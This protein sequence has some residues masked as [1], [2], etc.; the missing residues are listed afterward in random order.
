MQD[1]NKKYLIE[2]P[3]QEGVAYWG[4]DRYNANKDALLKDHPDAIIAEIDTYSADD[5]NDNDMYL[6]DVPGQQGSAYWDANRFN[7]N[8]DAL[9]KDHP[10]AQIQRV[11]AVDYWGEQRADLE[12]Q[13]QEFDAQYGTFLDGYEKK[14]K[15]DN[16][17]AGSDPLIDR[18]NAEYLSKNEEEYNRLNAE[19]ER[20]GKQYYNSE[21]VRRKRA[22]EINSI[23]EFSSQID[24]EWK[25][26]YS[27]AI[28]KYQSE[29]GNIAAQG[30]SS[31]IDNMA[32]TQM[33][34]AA[35]KMLQEA[36]DT[37]EAPSKSDSSNG[38]VNFMKGA[39]HTFGSADF[40][41][42]GLTEIADNSKIRAAF[43][44]LAQKE[45]TTD[46]SKLTEEQID[47]ALSP[48]EK[49]AVLAFTQKALADYERSKDIS[50]GYK[51][52]QS[53]AESL[54]F[55]AQFLLTGGVTSA[56]SKGAT[57]GLA[58]WLAKNVGN[59]FVAKA[60]PGFAKLGA[61]ALQ[62]GGKFALGTTRS[63]IDAAV[64]T[65]MT[66]TLG[67]SISEQALP[68]IYQGTLPQA[69]EYILKGLGDAFIEN[70]S[71]AYG[72]VLSK[73]V[74]TPAT[75]MFG[76]WGKVI[77]RSPM[78]K[79]L[80]RGG[81][82]GYLSE[83]GEEWFGSAM[84]TLTGVDPDALKNFWEK[85]NL[86]VTATSFL[87]M[88]LIGG[89]VSVGQYKA[90]GK[91][92][93]NKAAELRVALEK[94]GMNMDEIDALVDYRQQLSPKMLSDRFT[95]IVARLAQTGSPRSA[96]EVMKAAYGFSNAVARYQ[97]MEGGYQAQ[98]S[99]DREEY[100]NQLQEQLQGNQFWTTRTLT[101]QKGEE[102]TNQNGEAYTE[103]EVRVITNPDGSRRFVVG[104]NG[105]QIAYIDE[106]G[107]TGYMTT[108]ELPAAKAE[109]M[110]NLTEEERQAIRD[111]DRTMK[112]D[113]FLE[114]EVIVRRRELEVQRMHEERE[115]QKAD[116]RA[117]HPIGTQINLGTRA[118]PIAGTIIGY[119]P[120]AVTV[121]TNDKENPVKRISY[122]QLGQAFNT[123]I[124][125]L[126]DEQIAS[127]EAATIEAETAEKETENAVT[128]QDMDSAEDS[129]NSAAELEQEAAPSIVPTN[130]D[131]SV[132][133]QKFLEENPEEYVAWNDA[134]RQDGGADSM[135]QLEMLIPVY[136]AQYDQ[137]AKQWAANAADPVARRAAKESMAEWQDK[138][139]RINNLLDKYRTPVQE[140]SP[141]AERTIQEELE[142]LHDGSLNDAEIA[143][144]IDAHIA[145]AQAAYDEYAKNAP[146]M[147]TD[148]SAYKKAK[149]EYE[150]GLKE[151]EQELNYW[152]AV[153]AANETYGQVASAEEVAQFRAEA[154]E[155]NKELM[156]QK[157]RELEQKLGVKVNVI[158]RY[159]DIRNKKAKAAIANGT[160]IYGWYNVDADTVE[161]YLPGNKTADSIVLTYIHEVVGHK[162][163][164]G[165]LGKNYDALLD[166]VYQWMEANLN[167]DQLDFWLNYE[168][169]NGDTRKAADEYLANLAERVN[170][171]DNLT[172]WDK[173]ISKIK[174]ILRRLGIE[175]NM[176]KKDFVNLIKRSYE[177]LAEEA[178]RQGISENSVTPETLENGTSLFS[179]KTYREGGRE[180]LDMWL[181]SDNT[182]SEEERKY[183]LDTMDFMYNAA[184]GLAEKY[185]AFGAWSE[186]DVVRNANGDP[187]MSVI[188]ANGD[189]AMNLDFSLVCKKRRAL[190]ALLNKMIKDGRFDGM[191]L[192]EKEIARIN[193]ILQKHGFEVAC[194]LC[195]VD[196]KRYRVANVATQFTEMYN[197]LV[198]S[199]IPK[200]SGYEALWYNY[201]GEPNQKEEDERKNPE[202]V[203]SNLPEEAL[204]WTRIDRI[205]K[206]AEGKKQLNVQEKIAKLLK[207]GAEYRKLASASDFIS[208][209]GFE[210]VT[211]NNPEL[212]KLYNAKKGT[213][214][215]KASLGD[216]QY[217]NNIAKSQAFSA[218]KAYK[219]GGVR[220]QS[221]SDYM[222]HM[223]FDYMQMMAELAGK[224]LPAHA[225]TKEPA[226]ARLFGMTGMKINLSLVPRVDMDGIAPGLD[227]EGNYTW[228]V[229][230]V[231]EQGRTIATQTF[232]PEVAFE[233]QQDPRYSGNVGAIAV[234]ISDEHIL[235][236]LS[237]ANIHFI[238]PYHKSSLNPEVAKMA[239][240]DQYA[241]YTNYQ[242]EKLDPSHPDAP[243]G[244]LTA[245]QKKA[246]INKRKF[247]F[248][249]SLAQTNDPKQTAADYLAHCK[250]KGLI[251]KFPQFAS[252]EN[253]YKLL[254]DFN[255][256]DFV[257]GEYAPQGAVTM[258]FP[259]NMLELIE[260]GLVEDQQLDDKLNAEISEVAE[261]VYEEIGTTMFKT[262]TD[263]QREKLFADAK[264]EFGLTDNFNVAGYMLPDGSLLNFG[265]PANPTTRAEDHRA[266]EG[267]IMDNGT[268]YES[269]WMYLA[270]FMNEGAIRLLP[271]YAGINL[272]KAPTKE[273]R[274]RLMDFIYKYNGEVILEIADE[275]LNNAAYVEYDRRTSPARIFRDIDGYFNEGIVPQQDNTLFKTANR[276][277]AIFISNAAKAVEGIQMGKA[278]PEQWLKTLEKNG[279]LKAAEDKWLGLSDWLKSSDKKSITKEELL[280]FIN[281]N[282]IQ[283]EEVHYGEEA[284][285]KEALWNTIE[286]S[287]Q[288]RKAIEEQLEKDA[289]EFADEMMRGSSKSGDEWVK[290]HEELVREYLD[291]D[292]LGTNRNNAKRQVV[293]EWMK[294][295]EV[296]PIHPTRQ[297]YQTRGLTNNHEIALTVPTIE[298]WEGPMPDVHFADAGEGRAVAWVR[299]GDAKKL[300]G[301]SEVDGKKKLNW[302]K[303]LVIDEVQSQRHQEGREKG[304]ESDFETSDKLQELNAQLDEKVARRG[305][306]IREKVANEENE[307]T[308]I[309]RL[310]IMLNEVE[311][312]RNYDRISEE[313]ASIEASIENRTAEIE[314]LSAEINEIE[315]DIKREE[316]RLDYKKSEAVKDAPFEKNWH[317]LAMKRMLRYA[318]ENGYDVIAWTKGDQQAERYNIGKIYNE[319]EREDNPNIEGRTFTFSGGNYDMVTVNEDGVVV[320][321]TI[322]EAKGKPLSDLVGK[323]LAVKMMSL[324]NYDTIDGEDLRIGGEGMKGFYDKMLPSFMNKYGKKWGVKVEDMTFPGLEGG[325]TMHSIPVTEEMKESVMEGQLMFRTKQ[326]HEFT[327]QFMQG[328]VDNFYGTYNTAAPASVVY[329]KNRRMVE[330]ALG[331]GKGEMPDWLY[332]RVKEEAKESG[333]YLVNIQHDKEDG[334]TDSWRRILIFAKDE[335]NMSADV[336]RITFHENTH[337]FILD[338]PHWLE[339]GKWLAE[340][341]NKT[342]QRVVGWIKDAY[343]QESWANEMLSDYVGRMLSIGKGQ[344][345]LN[346]I[347]DEYKP[348]LNEIYEKFG[349]NPEQEDGRRS[350]EVVRD[351]EELQM[352]NT[353]LEGTSKSGDTRFKSAIT[354]EVRREMD[355]ISATAIVNGNYMKAPNGKDSKL[356]P[357]QWA[358]VRTKN[359]LNWFGDWINDPENASK[360]VDENGEPMVVYHGTAG[361]INKFEDQQ[362]SPGFW[363]VNREDVANGYAESASAEFG[364][365]KNIIPV[366]LN[367]RNPRVEDAH[368]E[369]PA[370]FALKSFVE[371]DKGVYEVFETYDEAEA[372]R[373]ENVPD[374]WVGAAEVGDQHDLVER[375]KELGHDG[376]IM[377]NM[378][379]QAAYAETE[380][381]GTQT[382][383]VVLDANQ[384]KSATENNGEYSESED[385]RF[386]FIG[387]RGA[388]NLDKFEEATIRLDNLAIAREM[389]KAGK[390]AKTI[391]LATGWEKGADDKWRYEVEDLRVKP[392]MD[393][394]MSKKKLTLKDIVEDSEVLRAYPDLGDI[395]IVK[396]KSKRDFGA[397][398]NYKTNE[399]QLPFGALK[400]DLDDIETYGQW[401]PEK[402]Q[403]AFE[404]HVAMMVEDIYHETQHAIQRREGFA[405]GGSPSTIVDQERIA[406]IEEM[407]Q[408][409]NTLVNRF[410]MHP[411]KR[412]AEA[413]DI[414]RQANS[415][416]TRI[417]QMKR[418]YQIGDEGYRRLAGEVEARNVTERMKMTTE[419][420][421]NTLASE[422][423]DVAREDQIVLMEGLGVAEM[424]RKT[425]AKMEKIGKHFEGKTLDAT[426]QTIVD[427]Y[428]GATNN[429]KVVIKDKSGVD[430]H[431]I[432]RQGNDQNFGTK[433]S[434]Y[435]HFETTVG[436]ISEDD[437][438]LIPQVVAQ[439]V[440]TAKKNVI[441]YELKIDKTTYTLL[442]DKKGQNEI[443]HDFFSS[444]KIK[445]KANTSTSSITQGENTQSSARISEASAL[446]GDKGTNNS[447]TDNTSE[448]NILFKTRTKPAPTKTQEA[449]KLMRLGADGRLYPLFIGSADA[450]ELGI[451][452]DADSPNLGDLTKLASGIHLVNNETGEAMTLDQFKAEH[453]EIAIKGEKPN[454][455]A[456]NW[457]TENG[458]RWISI[459]DKATAQKRYEGE[460]RSY[461]N[462]GINGSG[463]VG[464]FAMR[465]GWHAG[466][467][468]TM[469]QIGKGKDKNLRDD[470]F[471]WVKGRIPADVDYQSEADANPDKDIPTHIPTDGFYMKATNAN[472]KASQADKMGWYVA[473]SFIA[474]EIISDAEA[475]SV[476]DSWNAE[477]PD[478]QVEYDYERES[479]REFDP[480]QGGLVEKE[481]STLFKTTGTPTEEVV[482]KGLS[483]SSEESTALVADIFK[484]LPEDIR[485][486]VVDNAS[487]D[488][489]D[490]KKATFQI[491]AS[492]AK[493]ATLADD[494]IEAAKT[495]ADKVEEALLA[496]GVQMTRPI[497]TNE[498]LWMLYNV[499]NPANES[500]PF[501]MAERAVVAD[502]LGFS[503]RARANEKEDESEIRFRSYVPPIAVSAADAY[504]KAI[505]YWGNRM[506]EAFVDQYD[507]VDHMMK[508]IED[509]TGKKAESWEDIRILL[510][511][512]ASRGLARLKDVE[513]DL[514]Q[515]MWEAVNELAKAGATQD[516]IS[517]YVIL[518]HGLERNEVFAKRDAI[519]TYE[520]EYRTNVRRIK[521]DSTLTDT[522][523]KQQ[524][525]DAESTLN[526]H[527]DDVQN[528]VDEEYLK[529]REKDYSGVM[530]MFADYPGLKPADS[531]STEEEYRTERRKRRKLKFDN[532]A[533]AEE[534]AQKECDA[535]EK[536]RTSLVD[537]LWDSIRNLSRGTL[538][539]QYE[540]GMLG[541]DL[542]N[543]L[544]QMFEYY[545]PLRGFADN[546]GEDLYDYYSH[547]VSDGYAPP[548]LS[549]K[550][551]RTEAEGPFGWMAAMAATA[552][553]SGEKNLAKQA[554]YYF[555]MNRKANDLLK[556]ADVWYVE[557]PSEKGKFYPEYPPKADPNNTPAENAQQ[558]AD[559]EQRMQE[560]QEQG[561]AVK[562]TS[563]L[564]IEG[565][566]HFDRKDAP[567]HIIKVNIAGEQKILI[568]NANPR[569][570]QAINGLLNIESNPD[571]QKVLGKVL[572]WMSQVSTGWNPEF[573]M[574]NITRDT[575]TAFSAINIKEDQ[576]YNEAFR[577]NWIDAWK[578]VKML[579]KLKDGSLGTGRLEDLLREAV[580][581]GVQTGYSHIKSME[582]WDKDMNKYLHDLNK[583]EA[584]AVRGVKNF[585]DGVETFSEAMELVSRFA[586]YITSREQ[587]RS[588]TEAVADAKEVTVNFNRK[589]SGMRITFEEAK[590]LKWADGTPIFSEKWKGAKRFKGI[591]SVAYVSG[592]SALSPFG[593]K[594]MMFFNASI[595]GLNMWL[596]MIRK[597][598]GKQ[599]SALAGASF[600]LG[601]LNAVIQGML[602]GD[603]DDY[604]QSISDYERR[605]NLML[606][607]NG[608]YLKIALPQEIK[609]FYGLGDILY[610]Y[611]AGN[612]HHKDSPMEIVKTMG[613]QL[614]EMLPINP[615][616]GW[617]EFI[618]S[619]AKGVVEAG[620]AVPFFGEVIKGTNRDFAGAPI[621]E[622]MPWLNEEERKSLPKYTFAMED[623][624]SW[625]V[626][627][628]ELA[629]KATGGTEYDAGWLQLDPARIQHY[630]EQGT[631]GVGRFVGNIL[632]TA[633]AAIDPET[634][635]Q[636]S[637][638]PFL[639]KVLT[640]ADERS[641]NKLTNQQYYYYKGVAERSE[642][643][644]DRYISDRDREAAKR[645]RES[646]DFKILRV[647]KQYEAR[648]E[649]YRERLKRARTKEEEKE[650][651]K[652][653]DANRKEFLD[654][655]GNKGLL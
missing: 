560:L 190:N 274:Q 161:I 353:E 120:D 77:A 119:L 184:E 252:H 163:L 333:A 463:Q 251:P 441:K 240:I 526:G 369:Y 301:S 558:Y 433:H 50:L 74:S 151:L 384:I 650:L 52:G 421:R 438:L 97:A 291:E 249:G 87:P 368:A 608:Y 295:M 226:F 542:Y 67:R 142:D 215:P 523:R 181:Q 264:A 603:D 173:I 166:S 5:A 447:D 450:I 396:N 647:Y 551:R 293:K 488:N 308:D 578:V 124:R 132:N 265:D 382:N 521:N 335:I 452:Y 549:A 99:N 89:A 304:Y 465:P 83:I 653:R 109:T 430:R 503:E 268:E 65:G 180:Y 591:L 160:E 522:E 95:P 19:R 309:A 635:V 490:L 540:Y 244:K 391:K 300:L 29:G 604:Q 144:N 225:Y 633:N 645:E 420:R 507:A 94:L 126:T 40:W 294:K 158:E 23:K 310:N 312:V 596:Q 547:N 644:Y 317:E 623:T 616:G 484:A 455:A 315:S 630:I 189:Y 256:Y 233:M 485:R 270:D 242:T 425:D 179:V 171:E 426:Q 51:S 159:E 153:K 156:R 637:N 629:N 236:M 323:D 277:Q 326:P 254:V 286:N 414:V 394:L 347:P 411:Y 34:G 7:A 18:P 487:H 583:D 175:A 145:E 11:R 556:I 509:A 511:Q 221:F 27:D 213:G 331:F 459:E 150:A 263:S 375:A 255:T 340:T 116:L 379:D 481:G 33:Y 54:G 401:N 519:R 589:G 66:T 72:G 169:V 186:A 37:L 328:V 58:K 372:Y 204:D 471:V 402:Y 141:V 559:W 185:S 48:A 515:K 609:A 520:E 306:L 615:L 405:R 10:D 230:Y 588:I 524:M 146:V 106:K 283:I 17:L 284:Q 565:V 482:A 554:L 639:G 577:R 131:G 359:F 165:L 172:L 360:V 424:G 574:T 625:L 492:L 618:P 32:E 628:A 462:F 388:A 478:A 548:V 581:N 183:I 217:L 247:D 96:A 311:N 113:Q 528:G 427:T 210:L 227:A 448:E 148:R 123:P 104:V 497:T 472:A 350:A 290:R 219:V 486:Q 149:A 85:D 321:S 118:N 322:E 246:E 170:Y 69:N 479:G 432:M 449:Y 380:V 605:S 643:R 461:Y 595:Q 599:V 444:W 613:N 176:D 654:K 248:Y 429:K 206:K 271:E 514:I 346:L 49:A 594:Y 500:D 208:D 302:A 601:I 531:Y 133:E 399:M 525:D 81:F 9:L 20:L 307:R 314:T 534:A 357:E 259:D 296:K 440:R 468:P 564:D 12:R 612:Y 76:N 466:S 400:D 362:R 14:K 602:D 22:N 292:F 35:L 193:Q 572:R 621:R 649:S 241:D 622:E 41:T 43:E 513:R 351:A 188:K 117:A 498:G 297:K 569:A 8:K 475:R 167:E 122:E 187:I 82:N 260:E 28:V 387:E 24:E 55:M 287:E 262:R 26:R 86:I 592:I 422:T 642:T 80:E 343:E 510:N 75:A 539:M 278:A 442:L 544:T 98:E 275:R 107:D 108:D 152:N 88:T 338:N 614:F 568:L 546:T 140:Q 348:I 445:N 285:S 174:D 235:K 383:Y 376:V 56:A 624:W 423:E 627:V 30:A 112:L 261:E 196:A 619:M 453:P 3:G 325:L 651:K 634:D 125:V 101:N 410:N 354:P 636:I 216:V 332:D 533:D 191:V 389:E 2:I 276:S 154:A 474:D 393:W 253:Y 47:A 135:E 31:V 620:V 597:G 409:Q 495:I 598:Y 600:A 655:L 502:R 508:A 237:D 197:D 138:I 79:G 36:Q 195:F 16:L 103:D 319:I 46:I 505:S 552:V 541:A 586:T 239:K 13:M 464:Q 121:Q 473:G 418:R 344:M 436:V 334:T 201:M 137:A 211:Q 611:M 504:T 330:E 641:Q 313:I 543:T 136:Q 557:S 404:E 435:R 209:Q 363:F 563:K 538:K 337:G 90:A 162:G 289:K 377:M 192:R 561:K 93:E 127:E 417:N 532:L 386:K 652:K 39:G 44:R 129:A 491:A 536:G 128:P 157:A 203:I 279:G 231:D 305:E 606:G 571:Y 575:I 130:E 1:N 489:Y 406:A 355:V 460:S 374:G 470:S 529:N 102:I 516:E 434:L 168:N 537:N 584:K 345:A 456:I 395:A 413:Q 60:S 607:A 164:R 364:E 267:V 232:P 517:R 316:M 91:D 341:N 437:I 567:E 373:E 139:N 45:G 550:G 562:K 570:A 626:G 446:I 207:S 59:A 518:K 84:R 15:S 632:S 222:P 320:D 100:R 134:Q 648:Q 412:S 70:W 25:Q 392:I 512:S 234:G 110:P 638:V 477:H 342:I 21:G 397:W 105:D 318:A 272:I 610:N 114:E 527:I 385:I 38:F 476:I 566:V 381:K 587:G 469:R 352:R 431:I 585:I 224:R 415:L 590:K 428:S 366:F 199:L 245:A 356:T 367:I 408:E 439:G 243:K 454:V 68:N 506:N 378:Y 257:T 214:G 457:A 617:S 361:V 324:E 273:Q 63:L 71:E 640:V 390:D 57:S 238:I 483:L 458:M 398:Y 177:N 327:K 288:G 202:T 336:D 358:M 178:K 92:L 155:A 42:A 64:R 582:E 220:I 499:F 631:G 593:R 182:I 480:E 451:W 205:L 299:F 198:K 580:E 576:K 280:Q 61:K 339:L 250:E 416:F 535:F 266:I 111:T 370:E 407:I 545:V 646:D 281:E 555:A 228:A 282:M 218:E 115:E 493:K 553:V 329:V 4:E 298:S 269:R 467:L 258:T 212:L 194:A 496:S 349:Y 371:N 73:L 443:F 223:F 579:P 200:K 573:W 494:E 53:A 419:E 143:S 530:A 78:M 6:I 365:E 501:A 229:E 147:G 62:Q 303:V 403:R